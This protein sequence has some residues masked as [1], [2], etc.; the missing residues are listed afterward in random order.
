MRKLLTAVLALG[1]LSNGSNEQDAK[2][3]PTVTTE[4]M[5]LDYVRVYRT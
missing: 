5:Q 1:L 2:I 4:S 3:P